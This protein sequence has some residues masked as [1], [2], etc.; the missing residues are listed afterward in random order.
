MLK[1]SNNYFN[2]LKMKKQHIQQEVL[3]SRATT[4]AKRAL[5]ENNNPNKDTTPFEKFEE[6]VW[7]GLLNDMFSEIISSDSNQYK[8]IFIWGIY[9]GDSY[10]LVDLGDVPIATESAQ[11][12]DPQ[13]FFGEVNLN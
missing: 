12:I 2:W 10:L 5:V 4:L 7:N 3:V 8:K 9:S 1:M 6:A 13:L 11:S